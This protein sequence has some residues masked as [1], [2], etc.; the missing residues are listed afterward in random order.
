MKQLALGSAVLLALAFVVPSAEVALREVV[1]TEYLEVYRLPAPL[2]LFH[3]EVAYY[4][5]WIIVQAMFPPHCKM[6]DT[7]AVVVWVPPERFSFVVQET[8]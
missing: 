1:P 4:Q 3:L 5:N 8:G 7:L 6:A 2:R